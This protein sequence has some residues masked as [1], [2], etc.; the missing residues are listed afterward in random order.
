M[1]LPQFLHELREWIPELTS[2]ACADELAGAHA[3]I[4]A[5]YSDAMC[6]IER[7]K[8]M[9][10][11]LIDELDRSFNECDFSVMFVYDHIKECVQRE[12]ILTHGAYV[13][14]SRRFPRA[15]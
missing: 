4:A 12:M 6:I 3:L 10:E 14:L 9:P 1:L 13:C 15:R 8:H 5:A 11:R 2:E 7:N